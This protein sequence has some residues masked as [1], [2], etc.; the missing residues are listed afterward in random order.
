MMAL[1]PR[2]ASS[3]SLAMISFGILIGRMPFLKQLL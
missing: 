3:I 1:E 2:L